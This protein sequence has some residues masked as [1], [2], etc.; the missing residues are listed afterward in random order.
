MVLA[1][2]NIDVTPD[3]LVTQVY[4]PGREGTFP[5]DIAAA[6]RREGRL[7]VEINDLDALLRELEYGHPV[8]VMQNLAFNWFPQWHF[9]VA[10]GY[11][12]S[13]PQIILRSGTT[14]R[15]VTPL[16]AFERTW[17]RAENWALVVLPPSEAPEAAS[18]TSWLSGIAGLERAG[19]AQ[20]AL[21]A[22]RTF[23]EHHPTNIVAK[24]GEGNT[25][26]ALRDYASA[27]IAYRDAL[28]IDPRL[29]EAWNNL[30]YALY[31]QGN[32]AGAIDA[33][34]TA[35]SLSGDNSENYRDTLR[36]VSGGVLMS[37]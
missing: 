2:N 18:E 37:K 25:L 16:D 24:L 1:W 17:S 19:Q 27:E 23:L 35:V 28:A 11:D 3:D 26:L 31:H 13:G 5:Q 34:Q 30:A 8:L 9:A 32:N 29:A 15:L 33:A 4:T 6:A 22:Y 7:A 21:V 10:I 36:E 14:R 20:A 12:F